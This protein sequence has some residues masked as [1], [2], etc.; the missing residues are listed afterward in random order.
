MKYRVELEEFTTTP[1]VLL[2]EPQPDGSERVIWH[3]AMK[4]DEKLIL[5]EV[6]NDTHLVI[7]DWYGNLSLYHIPSRRQQAQHKFDARIAMSA[8]VSLDGRQI[9]VAYC[10]ESNGLQEVLEVLEIP[11]LK[12]VARHLLPDWDQI[13]DD[14]DADIEPDVRLFQQPNNGQAWFYCC[15]ANCSWELPESHGYY[16]LDLASGRGTFRS[17]P[18]LGNADDDLCR[19]ALNLELGLGAMLDWSRVTLESQQDGEPG[20]P[21]SLLL[22]SL[23]SF[24]PVGTLTARVFSDEQLD[25][26][27][28]L[29][30]GPEAD[31][32]A[33][34]RAQHDLMEQLQQLEWQGDKLAMTF[35]D[36]QQW[37]LDLQGG[38]TE[39]KT[40]EENKPERS[41]SPE[42]EFSARIQGRIPLTVKENIADTLKWMVSL[43]ADIDRQ[44][45]G[46]RFAFML[47]DSQGTELDQ[48]EFFRQAA[49]SHPQPLLEMLVHF[50]QYEDAEVLYDDLN[51]GYAALCHLVMGLVKTGNPLYLPAVHAWVNELDLDHELFVQEELLGALQHQFGRDHPEVEAIVDYT[52]DW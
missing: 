20:A 32:K 49:L 19:P 46:K 15:G 39:V 51:C 47:T 6:V 41:W 18:G 3:L 12:P 11:T 1:E 10:E 21:L 33:Y 44:R 24:E 35:M 40:E 26:L 34:S 43:C 8:R 38:L 23:D 16:Q 50:T 7:A 29:Q 25:D 22:F 30:A 2:I 28:Q 45:R 52:T 13:D 27:E 37:Q 48:A 42:A 14:C 9:L 4:T 36:Q 31:G 5:I 17:L